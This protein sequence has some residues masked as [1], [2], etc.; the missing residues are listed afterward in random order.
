MATRKTTTKR[1]KRSK[2]VSLFDRL[3]ATKYAMPAVFII[4]FAII[5][6]VATL[7]LTRAA[8]SGSAFVGIAG[9]CLDNASNTKANGNK[10]QLWECNGTPAQKW[11]VNGNGTI[12]N[13]NG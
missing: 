6:G 5:G 8:T 2:K 13:A 12:T 7:F 11:T 9:K 3:M 10:I 4:A 1:S